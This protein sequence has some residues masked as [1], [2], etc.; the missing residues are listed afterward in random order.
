MLFITFNWSLIS[1]G[2]GQLKGQLHVIT[3]SREVDEVLEDDTFS[4]TLKSKLLLIQEV[5]A[6]S[7]NELG[8]KKTDNY[9]TVFDQKRKPILW[10][11]TAAEQYSLK[12]YTWDFPVL[13]EVSYKGFFEIEKA[14]NEQDR[15]DSLG[16]DT[17]I[18]EVSAWS[19]LGWFRDPVLTN[20]LNRPD[21]ELINLIIHELTHSTLYLPDSVTFNE[22]FANFVAHKGTIQFLTHYKPELLKPYE[23]YYYDDSLYSSIV[24]ETAYK[25][26]S[27][28]KDIESEDEKEKKKLGII[29]EG[30]S[31]LKT[32]DY[33]NKDRY[34]FSRWEKQLPNNTFYLSFMRYE[35]KQDYFENVYKNKGSMKA[36]INYLL[37]EN[38]N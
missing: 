22:N 2:F 1:Y 17:N 6:F 35:S 15:L 19:T 16:F 27:F 21:Y 32:A 18:R 14:N 3:N 33:L 38:A 12:E 30:I 34:S 28:Y 7:E 5:K 23:S 4:D 37:Q 10:V 9:E 13:G 20:F 29:K 36:F 25:L 8:L 24:I 31:R 26:D 11:V